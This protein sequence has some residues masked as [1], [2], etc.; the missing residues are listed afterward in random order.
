[1]RKLLKRIKRKNLPQKS[2]LSTKAFL[3]I[4]AF[5]LAGTSFFLWKTQEAG[6]L[7]KI[8]SQAD[9]KARY[10]SNQTEIRYN[11]IYNALQRLANKGLPAG[12]IETNNWEKDAAFFIDSFQG[13][14]SI[15]W[16]DNRFFIRDIVPLQENGNY[17][18]QKANATFPGQSDFN[19]WVPV[20]D[21]VEFEGFILGTISIDRFISPV[22]EEI[23]NDYML[24]L[25]NEGKVVFISDNWNNPPQGYVYYQTITLKN[26]AVYN[27]AFAPTNEFLNSG[28]ASS[29]NTLV[30]SILLSL[31]SIIALH[32]A[33]NYNVLS[34]LN[35][36][37]YHQLLEDVQLVAVILDVHSRITFCNDYLLALTGWKREELIGQDWFERF[38]PS[39]WTEVKRIFM[40][41]MSTGNITVNYENPIL[42]RTGEERL[43]LFNNTVLRNTKGNI[44]GV[45]SLGEDITERKRSDAEIRRLNSTL[46]QRVEERTLEL[47][48]AQE[49]LIRQEKLATLGQIAG[50]VSHELRNPLGV[51]SNAIYYLKLVQPDD[52]DLKTRQYYDMIARETKN[53]EKIIGDLFEFTRSISANLMPVGVETLVHQTLEHFP[54]PEIIEVILDFPEDL[55]DVLVDTPQIKLAL[56]NLITN[57]YQAMESGGRLVISAHHEQDMV[58]IAVKDS[59]PGIPPENLKKL[60]EPLFT[61]KFT[62]IG[63]GL[64]IS[65]KLAEANGGRIEVQS[66]PGQGSTFTLFLTTEAT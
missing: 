57:A 5:C 25:S 31:I 15:A 7:S 44:I 20:Y 14:K 35:E 29:R 21:G 18:N 48:R 22:I 8:A 13:L 41:A 56:G 30:Y 52:A 64:A 28:K 55:P 60:F 54:N 38:I 39:D 16:V 3:V 37:R 59:G 58:S 40:D 34:R 2:F 19:L 63:L 33:Q 27:L 43:L 10:F 4:L 12:V 50:S 62:G 6:E 61:T 42:T 24:Q 53:A 66:Q 26:A 32:F 17:L 46:E 45:A 49:K 47:H 23:R 65:R 11:S 1:M 36:L 9:S 51:I